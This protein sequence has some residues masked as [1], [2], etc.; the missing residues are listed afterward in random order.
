MKYRKKPVTIEA[1]QWN[2]YNANEIRNFVKDTLRKFEYG[3]RYIAIETLE[4]TMKADINDYIIK[5]VQGEFYPCKPD[6][7][8]QTYTK[9][10]D[11]ETE[12]ECL[13]CAENGIKNTDVFIDIVDKE[14]GVGKLCKNCFIESCKEEEEYFKSTLQEIADMVKEDR[15]I[16]RGSEIDDVYCVS[17]CS[18]NKDCIKWKVLEKL[19][20]V[21]Q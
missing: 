13:Y 18:E 12:E 4:G 6:I 14:L 8:E 16:E 7:F 2:G 19:D 1:V 17:Y 11:E 15:K 9:V 5:G 21:L 20:E 10:E 3:N